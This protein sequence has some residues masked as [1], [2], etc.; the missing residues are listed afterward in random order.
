[1]CKAY[2]DNW[3]TLKGIEK[4]RRYHLPNGSLIAVNKP[5]RLCTYADNAHSIIDQN[6]TT[7]EIPNTW[8]VFSATPENTSFSSNHLITENRDDQNEWT[9]VKNKKKLIYKYSDI[10]YTIHSPIKIFIGIEGDH[11]VL[12]YSGTIHYMSSGFNRYTE[13]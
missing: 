2:K 7:H 13:V 6:N 10:K 8:R 4:A 9:K 5:A 3:Q 12:D 1:M 11:T